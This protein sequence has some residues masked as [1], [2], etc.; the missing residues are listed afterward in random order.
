M[1][2]TKILKNGPQNDVVNYG[3]Y[4]QVVTAN[5]PNLDPLLLLSSLGLNFGAA[6]I[7]MF[8]IKRTFSK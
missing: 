5:Q 3:I 8:R 7:F 4:Q 6:S 1:L 2:V